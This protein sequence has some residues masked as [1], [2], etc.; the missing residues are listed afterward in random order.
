M[1]R[2]IAVAT[3]LGMLAATAG[4][5]REPTGP[6]HDDVKA[7]CLDGEARE[8]LVQL[9]LIEG[10]APDEVLVTCTQA[11]AQRA[12]EH[13]EWDT[14]EDWLERLPG[15]D[16]VDPDLY[17]ARYAARCG[18]AY[19]AMTGKTCCEGAGEAA[20]AELSSVIEGEPTLRGVFEE[21][22]AKTRDEK[23][24][25]GELFVEADGLVSYVQA[26]HD[27][28]AA[29]RYEAATGQP[30]VLHNVLLMAEDRSE[31]RRRS[32]DALESSAVL[33][34]D[35]EVTDHRVLLARRPGAMEPTAAALAWNDD[36]RAMVAAIHPGVL[37]TCEGTV[38]PIIRGEHTTG[39]LVL[40]TCR[41]ETERTDALFSR[42]WCE[43]CG[44][45]GEQRACYEGRGRNDG[46]A[47]EQVKP[48]ICADL[49]QEGEDPA[50]CPKLVRW[51]R[52][53]ED[54]TGEEQAE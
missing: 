5:K 31:P 20:F 37:H 34:G 24:A 52:K 25:A 29:D 39:I 1:T 41:A 15:G 46:Q 33:G 44:E 13:D 42:R 50:D 27:L 10:E 4:C 26:L 2:W 16:D 38:A 45:R 7:T 47:I 54:H 40:A 8:G 18:L 48:K 49:L 28:A 35:L 32:G 17:L 53:C 14:L 51:S 9:G 3:A 19:A 6:T 30:L 23:L 21:W 22:Y 43:V 36:N 11:A 12:L